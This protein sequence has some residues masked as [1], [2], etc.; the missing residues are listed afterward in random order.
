MQLVTVD[1]LESCVY[2]STFLILALDG[3]EWS[4]ATIGQ[5]VVITK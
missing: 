4:P 1:I 5:D 3:S 2:L